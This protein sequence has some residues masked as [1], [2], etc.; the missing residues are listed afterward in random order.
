MRTL[1]DELERAASAGCGAGISSAQAQPE[2]EQGR[3][4]PPLPDFAEMMRQCHTAQE[5]REI[6]TDHEAAMNAVERAAGR[7]PLV[8]KGGSGFAYRGFE[9]LR[10]AEKKQL[11]KASA[12]LRTLV[13]QGD[14]LHE[15]WER[16]YD[17]YLCRFHG[18]QPDKTDSETKDELAQV[19]Q[20]VSDCI[21]EELEWEVTIHGQRFR[22]DGLGCYTNIEDA[23]DDR[24]F[25]CDPETG[26]LTQRP[27]CDI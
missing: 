21:E 27:D 23:D 22:R 11:A 17:R 1:F 6:L 9:T 24:I 14:R 20:Y 18:E 19:A 7:Q 8:G 26:E 3:T 2:N 13:D 4:P 25:E 12:A 5:G 10:P 16:R 15:V